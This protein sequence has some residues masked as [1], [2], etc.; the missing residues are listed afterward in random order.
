MPYNTP[1]TPN[2][3]SCACSVP[4]TYTSAVKV[5]VTIAL[6]VCIAQLMV[7]HRIGLISLA[8]APV[9]LLQYLHSI[10]WEIMVL[11][12]T[13]I[14]KA[15]RG[16]LVMCGLSR[17]MG[18]DKAEVTMNAYAEMVP[19]RRYDMEDVY[20]FRSRSPDRDE[21]DAALTRRQSSVESD[22]DLPPPY[23]EVVRSRSNRAREAGVYVPCL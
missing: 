11:V 17:L 6:G 4:E 23:S 13:V 16:I 10:I 5:L 19:V 14:V 15:G 12:G 21:E 8:L 2:T 18:R 22:D 7:K 20:H 1:N 9:R 3:T